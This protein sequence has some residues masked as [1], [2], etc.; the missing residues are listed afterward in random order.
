[1]QL[2]VIHSGTAKYVTDRVRVVEMTTDVGRDAVQSETKRSG[3]TKSR[4]LSNLTTYR[5]RKRQTAKKIDRKEGGRMKGCEKE[6]RRKPKGKLPQQEI[7]ITLTS[8]MSPC[9]C[10]YSANS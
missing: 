7:N 4:H 3:N 5:K 2:E 9:V 6:R 1:M 10:G 8:G